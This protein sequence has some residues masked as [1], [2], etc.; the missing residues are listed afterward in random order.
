MA[1]ASESLTYQVMEKDTGSP[2]IHVVSYN[3][4]ANRWQDAVESGVQHWAV[5]FKN[6]AWRWCWNESD[7]VLQSKA[8][9]QKLE[10]PEFRK[11]TVVEGK[12]A[13]EA[14]NDLLLFLKKAGLKKYSNRQLFDLYKTLFDAWSEM[15]FWGHVPNCADFYHNMLTHKITGFLE[16]RIKEKNLSLELGR[17]FS[18]IVFP[19]E[20][21][22]MQQY[23]FDFFALLALIQNTPGA[24]ELLEKHSDFNP[25]TERFEGIGGLE[26]FPEIQTALLTHAG[27]YDWLQSTYDGGIPLNAGYFAELLSSELRQ[28]VDG[29]SKLAEMQ[30]R[31]TKARANQRQLF[32]LLSLDGQEKNWVETACE[33]MSLKALRK[34]TVFK[35]GLWSLPLANEIG[36]RLSLNA[37]QVRHLTLEE[38]KNYLEGARVDVGEVNERIE[39]CIFVGVGK[40]VSVYSG[41]KAGEFSKNLV[42]HHAEEGV[43]ELKGT[44]AC[45]GLAQGVVRIVNFIEDIP[46][47]NEGE[48]L[49]SVATNP[50]LVPA[51]KKAGAIVTDAG[52]ITSHAAIVSRELGVPC[53]V[54]TKVATKVFKDG[55]FVEVDAT[56]GIVRKL[57]ALENG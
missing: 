32:E 8:V 19:A 47:L 18:E 34:E 14:V 12:R 30:E 6:R 24:S 11:K 7:F 16:K 43:R 26:A 31:E 56:R 25:A 57:G 23:E 46:K 52:G 39:H 53:V 29:E 3:M 22:Q 55:D 20:R 51:M 36:E 42:E 45:P 28:E 41:E 49:V 15:N 4:A 48:I 5:E 35:G 54:G 27:K 10:D 40:S 38:I 17:V 37:V 2:F 33:I 1:G 9:I 44:C 13:I 50:N 21:S